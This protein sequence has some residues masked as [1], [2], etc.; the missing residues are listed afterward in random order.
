MT[1]SSHLQKWPG[2]YMTLRL[3][4]LWLAHFNCIFGGFAAFRFDTK[5]GTKTLSA[6]Y[7]HLYRMTSVLVL[8]DASVRL[9]NYKSNWSVRKLVTLHFE[10]LIIKHI[11]R[12]WAAFNSKTWQPIILHAIIAWKCFQLLSDLL[13]LHQLP[14][15]NI[16][17]SPLIL[18]AW[19]YKAGFNLKIP[20]IYV[21]SNHLD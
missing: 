13:I 14:I 18:N 1:F 5:T 11:D 3:F 12:G 2:N 21:A 7:Q 19:L 20:T 10:K 6:C 9:R 8:N 16:F 17:A 4:L 15:V